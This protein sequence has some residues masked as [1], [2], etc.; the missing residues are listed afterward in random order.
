[1]ITSV[2]TKDRRNKTDDLQKLTQ[3]V[4]IKSDK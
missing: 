2:K 3:E 1:M 4:E